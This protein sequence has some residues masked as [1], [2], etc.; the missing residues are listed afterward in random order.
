MLEEN[1]ATVGLE[2]VIVWN[3]GA[4]EKPG[5]R[6]L[7]ELDGTPSRSTVYPQFSTL[8]STKQFMAFFVRLD[9]WF[10]NI[11]LI[12]IDTEG[13]EYDILKGA[14]RLLANGARFC[15]ETHSEGLY[16]DCAALLHIFG[17]PFDTMTL[18]EDAP[19]SLHAKAREKHKY[20]VRVDE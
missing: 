17:V 14:Q 18:E 5:V 2:N 9:D 12:K 6:L 20:L 1:V 8:A 11:S 3:V 7:S 13:S 10:R 19:G 16:A 4:A 15:I